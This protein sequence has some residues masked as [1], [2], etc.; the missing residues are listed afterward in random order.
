MTSGIRRQPRVPDLTIYEQ[1]YHPPDKSPRRW[2]FFILIACIGLVG[3]FIAMMYVTYSDNMGIAVIRI[4]GAIATGTQNDA[5]ISGSEAIGQQLRA[6][7]DDPMVEAIVIR[8]N[9]PGGTPAGAQE[10]I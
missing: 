5:D 8:I 3:L 4:D 10:I 1:P 2:I 6:A 9:S 7:A